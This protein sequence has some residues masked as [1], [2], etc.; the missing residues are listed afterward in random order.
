MVGP[1]QDKRD[2]IR[3]AEVEVE[4]GWWME[5]GFEMQLTG[6]AMD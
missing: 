3:V 5:V 1:K 6:Q 2:W 4:R